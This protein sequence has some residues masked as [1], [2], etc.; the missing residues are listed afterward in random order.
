MLRR[1]GGTAVLYVV[2]NQAGALYLHDRDGVF[3]N[4]SLLPGR[5]GRRAPGAH[6]VVFDEAAGAG[7]FRNLHAAFGGGFDARPARPADLIGGTVCWVSWRSEGGYTLDVRPTPAD[8]D[9]GVV[10][11]A[12]TADADRPPAARAAGWVVACC[13]CRRVRVA[14][15][16][17]ADAPPAAGTAVSH[18]FCPPCLR[19]QYPELFPADGSVGPA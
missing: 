7:R 1:D 14:A 13:V 10:G 16:V 9:G 17:W 15:D 18:G 4:R 19:A 5:A 12:A 8:A 11:E 6:V 3:H 2:A